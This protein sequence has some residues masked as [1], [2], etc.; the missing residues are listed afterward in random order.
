MEPILLL[1]HRIPYPPNKGDKI[2][3]HH[4]LRYLAARYHVHLGTFID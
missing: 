1:V 2:V 3:S 4:L